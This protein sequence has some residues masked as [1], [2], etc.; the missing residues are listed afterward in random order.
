[1]FLHEA[2]G[3]VVDVRKIKLRRRESPKLYRQN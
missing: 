3:G 1:V 2:A